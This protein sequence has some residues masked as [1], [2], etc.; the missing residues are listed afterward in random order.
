M[1]KLSVFVAT[2]F[3]LG[4]SMG[5]SAQTKGHADFFAGKWN[6]LVKG[7]P[8]GDTKMIV[9]LDKKDATLTGLIQ[10]STGT[11]IAQFSKVELVDST[12]TLYFTAQNYNVNL[13][14]IKKS[15]DRVTGSMMDMFDAEG[16]R[17]KATKAK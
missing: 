14:L 10:D 3:L 1:K 2:I 5:A 9:Q 15:Q 7:L 8:D 6:V 13:Q 4:F 11:E 17:V 12:V 16:D